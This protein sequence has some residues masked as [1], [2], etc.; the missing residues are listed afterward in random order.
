MIGMIKLGNLLYEN[1]EPFYIDENG[2]EIWNIPNDETQLKFVFKDTIDWFTTRY[3]NQKLQEIDEDL[4]DI[5]TEQSWLEGVFYSIGIDP[6]QIK[7]EVTK[8]VLGQQTIDDVITTLDIPSDYVEDFNRAVEIA[9][10]IAWK[11][12]IWKTEEQLEAQIDTMTMDELLNL[13]VRKVC[14]DTYKEIPLT[15]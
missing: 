8:V 10:I 7:A 4:Q 13:D 11:E 5:A 9:K 15:I 3:I 14:E 2:N 12:Q 1:I 6:S